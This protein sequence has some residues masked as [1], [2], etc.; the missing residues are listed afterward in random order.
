MFQ[1][2]ARATAPFFTRIIALTS[3]TGETAIRDALAHDLMTRSRYRL[4]A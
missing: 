2:R 1:A 3:P 4:G